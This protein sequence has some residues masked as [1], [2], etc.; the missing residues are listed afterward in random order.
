MSRRR[1]YGEDLTYSEEHRLNLEFLYKRIG[2]RLHMGDRD[3]TEH[4]AFCREPLEM[5]EQVRDVGQDLRDKATTW[6]TRVAERA[7]LPSW[8]MAYRVERPEEVQRQ[9]D[10]LNRRL[11]ELERRY[12]I[13]EFKLRRLTNVDGHR[14]RS[15]E[16]RSVEPA[17]WWSW[18]YL[19]HRDHHRTCSSA[20]GRVQ[21]VATD[22]MYQSLH[23]HPLHDG[24]LFRNAA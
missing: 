21:E 6:T 24:R 7:G 1:V 23:E 22:L 13:V 18:V 10:Q 8:V 12:P 19:I 15:R 17:A 3:W 16:F 9:I 20:R 5:Y 11:R 4:C 2:H 14:V